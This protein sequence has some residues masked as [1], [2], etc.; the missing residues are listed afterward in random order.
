MT[1]ALAPLDGAGIV[2][3]PAGPRW[4]PAAAAAGLGVAAM[5]ERPP[6]C[7]PAAPDG[8]LPPAVEPPV[9]DVGLLTAGTAG[10]EVC[11]AAEGRAVAG[12]VGGGA[13]GGALGRMVGL[14][15]GNGDGVGRVAGQ[16][17]AK[18]MFDGCRD[19]PFW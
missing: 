15:D 12:L 2:A 4:A 13:V 19:A 7:D 5:C 9:D 18:G 10:A 1:A 11:R 14:G 3:P 16:I 6:A 17:V 8:W